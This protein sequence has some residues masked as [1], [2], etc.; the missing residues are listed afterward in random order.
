MSTKP[1]DTHDRFPTTGPATDDYDRYT[2][3]KVDGDVILYDENHEDAWI[4]SSTTL[5]LEDWR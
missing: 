1:S 5:A 3:V 4:Q 2:S